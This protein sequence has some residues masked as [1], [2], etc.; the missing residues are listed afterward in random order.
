MTKVCTIEGCERKYRARGW[1]A[2]HW[3]RWKKYGTT[4]LPV[5]PQYETCAAEDCSET[6][7][8]KHSPWCETHYYRI[9]RTGTHETIR[10]KRNHHEICIVEGCGM[11]DAGHH[12]LCDKHYSRKM[13]NGDPLALRGPNPPR[14][15]ENARWTGDEATYECLHQR[16]K[17][18]RGLSSRYDCI[19]CGRRAQ[20][21]SYD[22]LDPDEKFQEDKGP[23]SLDINHYDPRCV[24]CH[25][26]FDMGTIRRKAGAS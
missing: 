9:R 4:D 6:P 25:K 5:R 16:L 21:W 22:H 10:V 14:G 26:R 3:G 24:R 1:C 18:V 12:R 15:P 17:K 8:S 11:R 2:T 13:R 23:F 7:R 19:D 20:H